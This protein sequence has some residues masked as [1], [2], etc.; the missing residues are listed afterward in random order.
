MCIATMPMTPA[1]T[2]PRDD[3]ASR[4]DI[5]KSFSILIK[6]EATDYSYSKFRGCSIQMK[7]KILINPILSMQYFCVDGVLMTTWWTYT[8]SVKERFQTC[9]CIRV[10]CAHVRSSQRLIRQQIRILLQFVLVKAE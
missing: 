3:A 1:Q 5:S 9:L 4:Q 2:C 10:H 6:F 7:F 8:C